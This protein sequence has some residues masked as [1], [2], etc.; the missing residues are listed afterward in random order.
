MRHHAG[1]ESPDE[2]DVPQPRDL[3]QG[4]LACGKDVGSDASDDAFP[5]PAANSAPKAAARQN[6]LLK[7][8]WARSR[9]RLKECQMS[10]A[11]AVVDY[12]NRIQVRGALQAGV[13]V[14]AKAFQ[15]SNCVSLRCCNSMQALRCYVVVAI[16]M[17]WGL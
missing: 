1:E 4:F 7:M 16:V 15:L 6:Q 3:S 11:K 5:A 17:D 12:A 9:N 13:E 14:S 2:D 8:W 10:Q